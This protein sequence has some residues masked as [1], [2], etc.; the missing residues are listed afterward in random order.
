MYVEGVEAEAGSSPGS[1]G[2]SA[3]DDTS[4]QAARSPG[5]WSAVAAEPAGRG[6][7]ERYAAGPHGRGPGQRLLLVL[8]VRR[9]SPSSCLLPPGSRAQPR[10]L[11]RLLLTRLPR[12][13]TAAGRACPP[14]LVH[15][16]S[17]PSRWPPPRW[18]QPPCRDERPCPRVPRPLRPPR[19]RP[20]PRPATF[21]V[22]AAVTATLPRPGWQRRA[23]TLAAARPRLAADTETTSK[24]ETRG[25]GARQAG[26]AGAGAGA[27]EAT[28][29]LTLAARVALRAEGGAADTG[30]TAAVAAVAAVV[31][32]STTVA[33]A[34]FGG[35]GGG[36]Y[37]ERSSP[38]RPLPPPEQ[39]EV[40]ATAVPLRPLWG[41]ARRL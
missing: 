24:V 2:R 36:S 20:P 16:H 40:A 12:W 32:A 21:L 35:G 3:A 31:I 17:S 13:H 28:G 9:W 23:V 37:P 14:S 30:K 15:Q 8:P 18:F 26:C 39:C 33:V 5:A 1:D 38:P 25:G 22:T 10:S 7:S 11:A 4:A 19:P 27:A 6:P 29:L 34:S 41:A